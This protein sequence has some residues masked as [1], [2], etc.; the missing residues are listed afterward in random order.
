MNIK[1]RNSDNMART[2]LKEIFFPSFKLKYTRKKAQ[3]HKGK[4][5]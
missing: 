4:R 3:V 2:F 5:S 1:L